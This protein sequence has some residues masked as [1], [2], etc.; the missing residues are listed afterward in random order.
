MI[1]MLLFFALFGKMAVN[2]WVNEA[3]N[4]RHDR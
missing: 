4:F 2:G 1:T 3:D